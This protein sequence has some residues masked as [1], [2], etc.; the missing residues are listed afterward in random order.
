MSE[1]RPACRRYLKPVAARV[2]GI[3]CAA[4]EPAVVER[5]RFLGNA[6]PVHSESAS[7][8]GLARRPEFLNDRQHAVGG[9]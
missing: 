9:L 6:P 3:R 2:G 4:H 7:Q 1:K 8:V 5:S